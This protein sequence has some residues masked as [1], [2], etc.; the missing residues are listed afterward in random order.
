MSQDYLCISIPTEL[1]QYKKISDICTDSI[2]DSTTSEIKQDFGV[3]LIKDSNG[4]LSCAAYYSDSGEL[5]KKIYYSGSIV[6]SIE[7][8]RNN[9]LHTI[10]IY[11]Q[12]NIKKKCIFNKDG[13]IKNT[14]CYE[15]NHHEQII[16]IKKTSEKN[17]YKVE[18]GYDDLNRINRRKI[19]F[20]DNIVAEQGYKYDILDRIIEYKD[21]NQTIRVL[22]LNQNNE[23]VSYIIT[24]KEGNSIVILNKYLCTE[25][26]GTEIDLNGHKTYLK[27]KSYV[28]NAMLKKPFAGEDDLDF[29][30]SNL[31]RK[32]A[33]YEEK[34]TFNTRRYNN[35]DILEAI[36]NDKKGMKM[37]Q[38]LPISIRKCLLLK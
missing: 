32:K 21:S 17:C 36:I 14:I 20:N 38:L 22:L 35:H 28:D 12:S 15:Y 34:C 11:S 33:E 31:K 7:H 2:K 24:D 5:M 10:E 6:S 18:Y 19:R 26:I 4:N 1:Q 37:P 27:D 29:A 9:L 13:K 3:K 30:I 8:Y 23:L 16:E 25:Y